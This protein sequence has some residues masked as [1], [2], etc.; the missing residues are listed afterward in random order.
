MHNFTL[1]KDKNQKKIVENDYCEIGLING[2]L[3][4]VLGNILNKRIFISNV[5]NES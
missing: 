5:I 3:K 1:L 4:L 2:F